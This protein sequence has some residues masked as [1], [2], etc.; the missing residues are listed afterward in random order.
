MERK[1]SKRWH[2][3]CSLTD[4]REG[5]NTAPEERASN[6][7]NQARGPPRSRKAQ[8]VRAG[9]VEEMGTA[10]LLRAVLLESA[11]ESM[12]NFCLQTQSLLDASRSGTSCFQDSGTPTLSSQ[13]CWTGQTRTDF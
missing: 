6:R 10:R 8:V 1:V 3:S 2:F 11:D 4:E 9:P 7:E 5:T 12:F 13:A